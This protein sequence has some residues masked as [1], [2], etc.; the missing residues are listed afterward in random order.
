[1]VNFRSSKTLKLCAPIITRSILCS[2]AY[3]ML[4]RRKHFNIF[5][6]YLK[7]LCVCVCFDN[8]QMYFVST[9]LIFNKICTSIYRSI[10]T[11]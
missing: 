6:V 5:D 10:G 9:A 4:I 7:S 3:C 2:C 1:M 8:D 11:I